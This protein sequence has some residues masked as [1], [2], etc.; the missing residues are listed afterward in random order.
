LVLGGIAAATGV[1]AII[2]GGYD[3][4]TSPIDYLGPGRCRGGRHRRS[5]LLRQ[6]R[7]S[8]MH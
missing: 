1:G 2:E 3:H 5:W 6:A 8:C 7:Y 4:W